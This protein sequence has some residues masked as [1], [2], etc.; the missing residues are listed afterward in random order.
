M[1]D[2]F[3][4]GLREYFWKRHNRVVQVASYGSVPKGTFVFQQS[5]FDYGL[6][7]SP[8]HLW[9]LTWK[10]VNERKAERKAP[11]FQHEGCIFKY[12]SRAKGKNCTV[13]TFLVQYTT[14]SGAVGECGV[15]AVAHCEG[16]DSCF[17]NSVYI[18]SYTII[19]AVSNVI[20]SIKKKAAA[21]NLNCARENTLSSYA[22]ELFIIAALIKLEKV[23]RRF[24][25]FDLPKGFL[26]ELSDTRDTC[27]V[28]SEAARRV[29]LFSLRAE[30]KC[31]SSGQINETEVM[32]A[33]HKM[34]LSKETVCVS[35]FGRHVELPEKTLKL[36]DPVSISRGEHQN[37]AAS[38][39]EATYIKI[40][41]GLVEMMLDE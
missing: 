15:D 2:V 40:L 36:V 17:R 26:Q 18:R 16:S 33:I 13:L 9:N 3:K 11:D 1:V 27:F 34:V 14:I 19:P 37:A 25:N 39:N 24:P 38:V 30:K 23:A 5:D 41:G 8:D 20:V 35:G 31:S 6:D 4:R 21:M 29:V 12:G 32:G 7:M 28:Y 22:W 10:C